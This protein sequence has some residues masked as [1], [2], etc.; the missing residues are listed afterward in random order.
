MEHGRMVGSQESVKE[1]NMKYA[2]PRPDQPTAAFWQVVDQSRTDPTAADGMITAMSRAEL[3]EFYWVYKAAAEL[4]RD[5]PFEDQSTLPSEDGV[6]DVLIWSV[7]QGEPYYHRLL[8][9]RHPLPNEV[10]HFEDV[11]GAVVVRYEDTYHEALPYPEGLK[12]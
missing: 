6:D 3:V 7:A 2:G 1:Q 8:A 9:G 12:P 10:E 4:L 11:Q 5:L